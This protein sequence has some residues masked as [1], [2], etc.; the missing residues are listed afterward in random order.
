MRYC[1]V[2]KVN[3]IVTVLHLAATSA[4]CTYCVL[5]FFHKSL[6]KLLT[7]Y[8]PLFMNQRDT[9]FCYKSLFSSVLYKNAQHVKNQQL[10]LLM[11]YI[12]KNCLNC[13]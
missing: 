11:Y 8:T 12:Y 3:I 5:S 6:I 13:V 1:A 4:Q 7:L 10:C 2:I 9:T